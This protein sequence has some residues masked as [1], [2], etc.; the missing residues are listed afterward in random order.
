MTRD[1]RITWEE[2][3]AILEY[4]C[5]ISRAEAEERATVG[6]TGRSTLRKPVQQELF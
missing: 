4:R 2:K 5:H 6:A 3:A 1:E